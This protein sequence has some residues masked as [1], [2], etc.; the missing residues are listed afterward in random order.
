MKACLI[1]FMLLFQF[2]Q[3]GNKEKVF[4]EGKVAD[5]KTKQAIAY[6]VI[7]IDKPRIG[8]YTDEN[9]YYKLEIPDSIANKK[10]KLSCKFVGMVDQKQKIRLKKKSLVINFELQERSQQIELVSPIH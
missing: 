6:A 1:F 2:V 5:S 9:G 10:I 7:Y 8:I 3:D 4:I